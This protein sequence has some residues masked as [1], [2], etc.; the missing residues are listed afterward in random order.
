M[1]RR[2]RS[3]FAL[4]S[5]LALVAGGSVY[6]SG[7]PGS[8]FT[9]SDA[10]SYASWTASLPS[11]LH[12]LGFALLCAACGNNLRQAAGLVLAWGGIEFAAEL[13]QATEAPALA[14]STL[15]WTF[16]AGDLV[17]IGAGVAL[18]LLVIFTHPDADNR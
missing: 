10:A 14:G 1:T 7:R 5:V 13:S 6:L 12:T 11:L 16:D 17:A 3:E 2:L 4:L 15:R 9:L 8:L 18:A